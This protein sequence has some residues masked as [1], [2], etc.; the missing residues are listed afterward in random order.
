MFFEMVEVPGKIG[1]PLRPDINSKIIS[2]TTKDIAKS[3]LNKVCYPDYLPRVHG[4]PNKRTV[5][6][7]GHKSLYCSLHSHNNMQALAFTVGVT[8]PK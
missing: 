7:R 1:F 5:L 8:T 2:E 6:A 3:A 4:Q